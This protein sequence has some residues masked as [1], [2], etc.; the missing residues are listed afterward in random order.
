LATFF[1]ANLFVLVN[2]IAAIS[3][4]IGHFCPLHNPKI[5]YFRIW[6]VKRVLFQLLFAKIFGAGL[7]L[8]V[9]DVIEHQK[10]FG[11]F[12]RHVN[13]KSLTDSTLM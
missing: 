12:V 9:N 13:E 6:G 11:A 8:I 2:D 4:K 7:F 1:G 3:K 5:P 10:K